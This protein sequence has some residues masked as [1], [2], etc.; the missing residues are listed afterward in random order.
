M[1][2]NQSSYKLFLTDIIMSDYSSKDYKTV[3]DNCR[4]VISWAVTLYCDLKDICGIRKIGQL[5]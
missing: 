4:H 1:Q 5:I 3:Q 2:Y